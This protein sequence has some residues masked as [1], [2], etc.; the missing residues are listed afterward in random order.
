MVDPIDPLWHEYS[1]L[2][3]GHS[4]S[5]LAGDVAQARHHPETLSYFPMHGSVHIVQQVESLGY[6]LVAFGDGAGLDLALAGR[7]EVVSVG[8]LQMCWEFGK[9]TL[10]ET[11][12]ILTD[13]WL[14]HELLKEAELS[15]NLL[16]PRARWHI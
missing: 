5:V 14:Y 3:E 7:V 6:Q 4:V 8:C 12:K 1:F 16:L 10:S 9:I 13:M 2:L 11:K 15:A